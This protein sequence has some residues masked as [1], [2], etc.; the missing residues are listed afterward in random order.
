MLE[1]VPLVMLSCSSNGVLMIP[2]DEVTL[3]VGLMLW[4]PIVYCMHCSSGVGEWSADNDCGLQCGVAVYR[5]RGSS[6]SS[7]SGSGSGSGGRQTL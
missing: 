3:V 4:M 5:S 6:N 1:R 2:F 7:G